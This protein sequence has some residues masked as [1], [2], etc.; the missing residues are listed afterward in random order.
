MFSSGILALMA[1]QVAAAWCAPSLRMIPSPLTT[2]R[3]MPRNPTARPR[4][5]SKITLHYPKLNN[6]MP[7]SLTERLVNNRHQTAIIDSRT[8]GTLAILS[9]LFARARRAASE[10]AESD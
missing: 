1:A 8:A 6:V 3:E 2:L 5:T 9:S 4:N 7:T 10:E